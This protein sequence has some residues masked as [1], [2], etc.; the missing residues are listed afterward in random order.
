MGTRLDTAKP[1]NI[2]SVL[3][4]ARRLYS[5]YG[6]KNP[7]LL[8]PSKIE[9]LR[10]L[11]VLGIQFAVIKADGAEGRVC[12]EQESM[13]IEELYPFF[14]RLVQ[15]VTAFFMNNAASALTL[16]STQIR[17]RVWRTLVEDK[18][19]GSG[20]PLRATVKTG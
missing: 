14:Q 2:S 12:P 11:Q 3:P 9:N 18:E 8:D 5:A 16:T 17:E 13:K 4:G 1:F 19:V 10:V 20:S 6:N 15:D 7:A